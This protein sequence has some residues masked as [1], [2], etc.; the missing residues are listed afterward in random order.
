MNIALLRSNFIGL[1]LTIGAE[2]D[3]D[4]AAEETSK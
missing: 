4:A 3:D 2:R 1:Q